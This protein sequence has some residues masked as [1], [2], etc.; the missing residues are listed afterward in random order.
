MFSDMI[1]IAKE[2]MDKLGATAALQTAKE[3]FEKLAA[4]LKKVYDALAVLKPI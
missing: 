2:I 3:G 1:G 4:G